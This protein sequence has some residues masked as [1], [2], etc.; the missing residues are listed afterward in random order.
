MILEE[1]LDKKLPDLRRRGNQYIIVFRSKRLEKIFQAYFGFKPGNKTFSIDIPSRYKDTYLEDYFWL[2]VMDGDGMVARNSRKIV[3]ESG[4]ANLISSFERFLKNKEIIFQID[5]RRLNKNTFFRV[6]IKSSNFKGY[7]KKVGF[8]H[9]RKRLWLLNHLKLNDYYKDNKVDVKEYLLEGKMINY[10]K[11]FGL[12]R[13]VIIDGKSLL[14]K[15]NLKYKGNENRRL[16]EILQKFESINFSKESLFKILSK[17]RWKMSK[18]STNSIRMPLFFDEDIVKIAKFIRLRGGSVGLSNQYI[19]SLNQNPNMIIKNLEKIFDIKSK[20][21][22]RGEP[23]F[24]SG[25]LEVFFSKIIKINKKEYIL[26]KEY[27]ELK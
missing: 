1:L 9:P 5:K 27:N 13:V 2:G 18:G 14:K 19:R 15:Y 21:T 25:V 23:I 22:S 26:L 6:S 7:C 17:H 16:S 24:C 11:I 10:E 3:L 12:S 8:F 4:S 20:Y